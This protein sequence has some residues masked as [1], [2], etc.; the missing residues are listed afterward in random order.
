VGGEDESM[1]LRGT[2]W[3]PKTR[4]EGRG[5]QPSRGWGPWNV[6]RWGQREG[7]G[8]GNLEIVEKKFYVQKKSYSGP[9]LVLAL[10]GWFGLKG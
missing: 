1:R 9:T 7:K 10:A 4:G 5:K 6:P 8:F 2:V 3:P